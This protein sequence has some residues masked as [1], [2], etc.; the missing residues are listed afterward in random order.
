MAPRPPLGGQGADRPLALRSALAVLAALAA[1]LAVAGPAWSAPPV[2]S[3]GAVIGLVLTTWN[4]DLYQTPEMAECPAGLQASEAEQLNARKDAKEQLHK[5]GGIGL[6]G[7][8]GESDRQFPDLV[9]DPI[10]F[11]ELQTK[12]GYGMNLDGT[13]DGRATA[14]SCQHEKFTSPQGEAVDNQLARVLGCTKGWRK[15]G[16]NTE[17]HGREFELLHGNRILI[18]ITGVDDEKNDPD[19][20]VSIYKGLD[21]LVSTAPGKF[22]PFL[23][24]RIDTRE[25]RFTHKT[26]GRIVD[27]VL[28]TD[29]IPKADFSVTWLTVPAERRLKDMRLRLKLSDTGAEG[30][31]GGYEDLK[32]W[33][34]LFAKSAGMVDAGQYS[35]AP[36]YHAMKRYADGV[37]DPATGQCTAISA[38]YKVTA[39]RAMIAHPP[40]SPPVVVAAQ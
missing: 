17:F 16:F 4:L 8:D 7:P 27:G 26:H 18:E 1:P 31:V 29:P 10:P 11:R 15:D 39:V 6:R 38:A 14:K 24:Q 5:Y 30:Y 28:I 21:R 20:E 9:Q 35:A 2:P 3:S 32:R 19:V 22:V 40:A 13:P 37:P 36:I 25:P 23:N 33:W 12:I 34:N